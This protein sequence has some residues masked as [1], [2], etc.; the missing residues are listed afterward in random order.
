MAERPDRRSV[1]QGIKN[2]VLHLG[3]RRKI[4]IE[5]MFRKLGG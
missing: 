5:I 3:S 4:R 1:F 2:V